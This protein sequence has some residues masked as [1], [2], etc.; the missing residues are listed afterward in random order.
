MAP[1]ADRIAALALSQGLDL[2]S[3]GGLLLMSYDLPTEPVKV[4]FSYSHE[5]I[6][7]RKRL[8]Q[9]LANLKRQRLI[10]LWHDRAIIAGEEWQ[11]EIHENLETADVILLLI[12][13]SFMDSD[14]CSGIEVVRAMERH[15]ERHARV[16]PVLLK[17]CDWEGAPFS[18]LQ[19]LPNGEI[20]IIKWRPQDDGLCNVAKGIRQVV[21]DLLSSGRSTEYDSWHSNLPADLPPLVGR[22]TEIRGIKE[23]LLREDVRLLVLHGAPGTGKTSLALQVAAEV[24][25]DFKSGVRVVYLEPIGDPDLVPS[26]IAQCLGINE[27]KDIPIKDRLKQFLEAKQMLLLL[28]NFEH[29]AAAEKYIPDLL[30]TCRHIKILLTSRESLLGSEACH[31]LVPPM[32]WPARIESASTEELLQ[33][34]AVKLFLERAQT[35]NRS[36]AATTENVR[37]IARICASLGGNPL[38]IELAAARVRWLPL[39]KMLTELERQLDLCSGPDPE[40]TKKHQTMRA[41]IDWSYKLLKPASKGLLF[42]RLSVFRRGFTADAAEQVCQAPGVLKV[43]VKE[44]LSA[45]AASSL[46]VSKEDG[47]RFEMLDFVREYGWEHLREEDRRKLSQGHAE[48]FVALAEEAERHLTSAARAGWLERLSTEHA[49]LRAAFE[50]CQSTVD[51]RELGLR[52]A[53]SLFWFWNFRSDF[54]EGRVWLTNALHQAVPSERTEARAKALYGAGGLAFLQGEFGVARPLLAESVAIWRELADRRR[55]GFALIVLGMVALDQGDF[56]LALS[57]ETESVG[58]F[59]EM[60]DPWGLALA[61][62]DLGNVLRRKP[63]SNLSGAL[64]LYK[65]SL[66]LWRK[67][68][69]PWGLPLTLSNIGILE[70]VRDHYEAANRAFEEALQMQQRVDDNWGLAETLKYMADLALR[71]GEISRAEKL[72]RESLALNQKIGRHQFIAACQ[73][74]LRTVAERSR[75]A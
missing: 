48:F 52:L 69:D 21:M 34:D 26:T 73:E 36:L 57:S 50:W 12:S 37:A 11:D 45:L 3:S 22:A 25:R 61:L 14:Y 13:A 67:M 63:D 60:E 9:H 59:G 72:Y 16:I 38:A 68:K 5:D 28:D 66:S 53:G 55:L 23:R 4:F 44:G 65:R 54:T 43:N 56:D 10:T 35:V 64:D 46:L 74:G 1:G 19:A 32:A 42:K 20:P 31:F 41:A 15:A 39:Q 24:A 2:W 29:V 6:S 75:A 49:N 62:N 27:A 40:G 70:T 58:I 18:K 71:V 51:G 47:A 33:F 8:G 17:P 7:L 30:A